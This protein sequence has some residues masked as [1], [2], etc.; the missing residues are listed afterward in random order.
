MPS[1]DITLLLYPVISSRGGLVLVSFKHVY[2]FLIKI[3]DVIIQNLI[4]RIRKLNSPKEWLTL[5][6]LC[7]IG[8]MFQ[9][10]E[11]PEDELKSFTRNVA[12]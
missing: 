8:T 3:D 2:K 10:N 1:Q 6:I 5:T 11:L 9:I 4:T 7:R 12:Q